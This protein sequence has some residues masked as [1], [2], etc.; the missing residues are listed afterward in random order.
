[1]RTEQRSTS[2][3]RLDRALLEAAPRRDAADLLQSAPGMVVTRIEG[4]AVGHRLMLRGFDADH[5]QDIE[6]TVDG[7]PV[8][9]PSHIHGQGYADLGFLIPETVKS[10]RVIEGVRS[11]LDV[12]AS[13]AWSDVS[14]IVVAPAIDVPGRIRPELSRLGIEASVVMSGVVNGCVTIES[15][16]H[17]PSTGPPMPRPCVNFQPVI[18][19]QSG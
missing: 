14:S 2:D 18:G 19:V 3:L 15:P 16:P 10:L 13:V 17:G 1:M 12:R 4:D 9:Q 11:E 8:N 7:V 6:L 5:G